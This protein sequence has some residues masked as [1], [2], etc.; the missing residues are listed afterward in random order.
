M[1]FDARLGLQR[2]DLET[3]VSDLKRERTAL[4][5]RLEQQRCDLTK[6]ELRWKQAREDAVREER[7]RAALEQKRAVAAVRARCLAV[8]GP[9]YPEPEPGQPFALP[10]PSDK[11]RE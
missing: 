1:G 4:R 10:A 11:D 6:A 3:R 2:E 9:L 5:R 8:R 7:E